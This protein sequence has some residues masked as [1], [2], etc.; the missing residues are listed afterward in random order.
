MSATLTV[1]GSVPAGTVFEGR[2]G[3]G[4]AVRPQLYLHAAQDGWN[5][6]QRGLTILARG[7]AVGSLVAPIRAAVAGVNASIA[8]GTVETL[9][10]YLVK[11]LSAA[12]FRTGLMGA[13]GLTAL[14]LAVLG[15]T[16]AM[17]YS[18]SRRTREMGIRLALGAEPTDVRGLVLR[19]AVRLIFVG[20]M[21][22]V[23]VALGVAGT[24]DTLLFEVGARDPSVY[25]TVVSVLTV[26]TLTACYLPANRA[27]RVDPIAALSSE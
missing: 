23:T 24:L 15:I 10:D 7:T 6:I 27:S 11:S 8:I 12:R 14:L 5:G 3:P 18:V 20:V 26:A 9:D 21:I 2:L 16:G 19:E 1:I 22:G 25:L 13:F 17:A 4:E